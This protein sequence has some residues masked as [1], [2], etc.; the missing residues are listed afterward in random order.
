M[1]SAPPGRPARARHKTD[2]RSPE[3][4]PGTDALALPHTDWLRHELTITGSAAALARFAE[5]AAGPGAIPWAYPGLDLAAEDWFVALVHPP[6]GSRGLSVAAAKVLAGELR[7]A[8]FQHQA[9]VR[10]QAG[11]SQACPFDLHRLVPVPAEI[12]EL[13]P[14]DRASIA[15]LHAHWGTR[16]AL[17]QVRLIAQRPGGTRGK[18]AEQKLEFWA[19][20][21]TPWA[22]F[23]TLRRDWPALQF[24]LRPDYGDG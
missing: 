7:E 9:K 13:G 12:L 14:D 20:D 4:G 3:T 8:V 5:A 23:A 11:T 6:D 17:R 1:A 19:A 18:G 2:G 15:W 16:Q 10:G 21:W 24:W 22:G